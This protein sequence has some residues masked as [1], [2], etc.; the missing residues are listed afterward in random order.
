MNSP[1]GRLRLPG[2]CPEPETRP[3]LDLV[4]GERAA[5]R[6]SMICGPEASF[7]F[8]STAGRSPPSRRRAKRLRIIQARGNGAAAQGL[9]FCE[10]AS[11][12]DPFGQS[13]VKHGDILHAE[14]AEGPPDARRENGQKTDNDYF[15]PSPM[16]SFRTGRKRPRDPGACWEG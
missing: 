6:A 11:L 14:G 3:R 16:P 9:A 13:S 5:E 12:G 15:M 10:R 8:D 7:A 1:Q 4:A 2:I